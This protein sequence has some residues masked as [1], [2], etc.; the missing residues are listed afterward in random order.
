MTKYLNPVLIATRK[1]KKKKKASLSIHPA[2]EPM[3]ISQGIS[4]IKY[5]LNP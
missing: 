4:L 1:I 5:S 2:L 3:P